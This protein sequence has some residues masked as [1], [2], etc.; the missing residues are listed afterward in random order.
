MGKI[1][2]Q[3]FSFQIWVNNRSDLIS[4]A[5]VRQLVNENENSEFQSVNIRLKI[6]LVSYP[7]RVEGLV[8]MDYVDRFLFKITGFFYS[9]I[10]VFEE[11]ISKPAIHFILASKRAILLYFWPL[12]G[13]KISTSW[14]RISK[15]R[16]SGCLAV[17]FLSC[18]LLLM[19]LTAFIEASIQSVFRRQRTSN[20]RLLTWI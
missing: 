14:I 13:L 6:D 7:V 20:P 11:H 5:L 15:N 19:T 9:I 10:P 8:N 18:D 3:L 12:S 17:Y 16:L 1:W 2:I 4:S